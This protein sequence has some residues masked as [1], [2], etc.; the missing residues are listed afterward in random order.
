MREPSVPDVELLDVI[1]GA[2]QN[3]L[4]R[5]DVLFHSG[6]DFGYNVDLE[7]KKDA[8]VIGLALEKEEV[9]TGQLQIT[10]L[11]FDL[12]S[13]LPLLV[14][15]SQSVNTGLKSSKLSFLIIEIPT[16]LFI[17]AP[18]LPRVADCRGSRPV[19]SSSSS[20]S[21]FPGPSVPR[22]ADAT[23]FVGV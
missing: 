10:N 15:Q 14:L 9:E 13:S 19:P 11:V 4:F 12:V 5:R 21:S 16:L 18:P 8:K 6:D 22:I 17:R 23:S 2:D 7:L 1:S 3:R 20:S